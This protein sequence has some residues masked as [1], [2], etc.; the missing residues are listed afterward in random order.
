MPGRAG[1]SCRPA[2][3]LP[4]LAVAGFPGC[5]FLI[6]GFLMGACGDGGAPSAPAPPPTTPSVPPQFGWPVGGEGG[7]DWVIGNHVDHDPGSGLRDYRGGARVYDGHDGTDINSPNFRWMDRDFPPV[8]AAAPGHVTG[9]HDTEF[10]RNTS[11]ADI[12]W[13]F[14]EITH[15]DGS[16]TIYGHLK[17]GSVAVSL[18][19]TVTSGQ[20]LGVVGSSDN[21]TRPHLHFEVRSP[22]DR[23]LD[24][25]LK[26]RWLDPP[27]YDSP[28][29]LMDFNVTARHLTLREHFSELL[30]DP[31]PNVDSVAGGGM[32]GVGLS[33]AGGVP[34]DS[35]RLT[36][37]DGRGSL[38][39]WA[40]LTERFGGHSPLFWNTLASGNPGTWEIAIEVNG[41]TVAIYPIRVVEAE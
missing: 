25:F 17:K 30:V 16:R 33:L 8:L 5:G 12:P 23:V 15:D 19:E 22:S 37:H 2:G 20:H 14:V 7:A 38:E 26:G 1:S 27:P 13:N 40:D 32:L 35:I 39:D 9:T 3:F 36:L 24:P 6:C 18:G 28:L 10:D 29:A 4:P 11:A 41:E 31:P 21:S 34:G